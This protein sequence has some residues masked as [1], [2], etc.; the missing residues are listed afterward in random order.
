MCSLAKVS[1]ASYYR[2]WAQAAPAE[3]DVDRRN[4]IQKICLSH[5]RYGYRRAGVELRRGPGSES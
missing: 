1:R 3:A 5:R 4:E 2:D